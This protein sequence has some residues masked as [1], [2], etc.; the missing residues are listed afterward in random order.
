EYHFY[1]TLAGVW[2]LSDP[3]PN[4]QEEL[5][6]RVF[7]YMQK[8]LRKA[9]VHSSWINPN[10]AYEKAVEEFIRSVLARSPDS[11]FLREFT[12]FVEKI[13]AP[14]MWNSLSQTLLK[15]T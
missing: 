11:A 12:G 10:E 6:D 7:A 9:K 15:I 8:A 2:P 3:E 5:T 1:Q 4:D 14:G 13:K